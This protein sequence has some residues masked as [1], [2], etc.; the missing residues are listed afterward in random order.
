MI[1]VA[2]LSPTSH[3]VLLQAQQACK[4][5]GVDSSQRAQLE[6]VWQRLSQQERTDALTI[7]TDEVWA[8]VQESPD[9]GKHD[10]SVATV[11]SPAP[12]LQSL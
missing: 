2:P 3:S 9:D 8:K 7:T 6:T 4:E 10:T 1:I 11:A 12:N 5:H